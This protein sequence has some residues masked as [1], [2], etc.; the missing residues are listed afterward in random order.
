MVVVVKISGDD[1]QYSSSSDD[2]DDYYYFVFCRILQGV[3]INLACH[4]EYPHC[5]S[6]AVHLYRRWK[7]NPDEYRF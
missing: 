3:I 5:I 7:K 1:N 2:D 6:K 4:V